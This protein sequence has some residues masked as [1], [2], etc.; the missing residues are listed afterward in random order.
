[1]T[2]CRYALYLCKMNIEDK[3]EF[4]NLIGKISHRLSPLDDRIIKMVKDG[5]KLVKIAEL[6]GVHRN[7]VNY[8]LIRMRQ[9]LKKIESH[10]DFFVQNRPKT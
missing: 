3:T 1:M 4:W 8:R 9:L 7:T 5:Y 2:T 6:L 10:E